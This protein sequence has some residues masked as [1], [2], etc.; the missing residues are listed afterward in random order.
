[1]CL[2]L[3]ITVADESIVKTLS[4]IVMTL[5]SSSLTVYLNVP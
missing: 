4:V 1:M 3:E 2:T 5:R